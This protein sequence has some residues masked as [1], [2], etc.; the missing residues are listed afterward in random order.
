MNIIQDKKNLLFNR[1]EVKVLV[2]SVKTPSKDDALNII[3]TNFKSDPQKIIIE[4]VKGKFGR[5]TFLIDAKI[6]NSIE[7]KEKIESH[8]KKKIKKK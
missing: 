2:E 5:K 6:Y 8:N 4:N 1:K 3:S 7:D